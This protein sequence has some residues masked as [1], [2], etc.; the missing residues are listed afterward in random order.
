MYTCIIQLDE[1]RVGFISSRDLVPAFL[2]LVQ[3]PVFLGLRVSVQPSTEPY[4]IRY[5]ES[6]ETDVQYLSCYSATIAA[7]WEEVCKGETLLYAAL[8]FFEHR[9]Q[10][11]GFVTAHASAV[12][13]SEGSILIL[14]KEGSGKT[15]VALN[16]CRLHG[17]KLIGNDLVV[18]GTTGEDR[19]VTRD[20][21]KFLSLRYESI[22]RNI[23]D[24]LN[25]FP[26]TGG[27]AWLRKV[28]VQPS[29][30]GIT[31]HEG[32]VPL[33]GVYLV[34]VD[35]TKDRLFVKSADTLVTRLY[36]NENFSRYI[37]GTCM[38][39]FDEHLRFLGYVP[40]VDSNDL[41]LR[42][43]LLIDRLLKEYRMMYISGPLGRVV[44]Y[45]VSRSGDG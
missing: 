20:G 42:R 4:Q 41:F 11:N 39:L 35:E 45:I 29:E 36:L 5:Q 43:S 18:V 40:S 2:R 30:A 12:A 1:Y 26:E 37:R 9:R 15:V 44:E 6:I 28:L 34:H 21:T 7:S 31:I 13:L 16:L 8:P 14:G 38:S 24:L 22:S 3:T 27:D 32:V 19:L 33:T 25:L 17:A 23:P 10:K